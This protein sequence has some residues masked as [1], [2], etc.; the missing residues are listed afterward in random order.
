MW[1]YDD[2][3]N[4][5]METITHQQPELSDDDLAFAAW[6]EQAV[7]EH[8]ARANDVASSQEGSAL[9][10][11]PRALA[12]A[13]LSAVLAIAGCAAPQ[14]NCPAEPVTYQQQRATLDHEP[15]NTRPHHPR[16]KKAPAGDACP[17]NT[18]AQECEAAREYNRCMRS[19]DG[20]TD[21]QLSRTSAILTGDAAS[22]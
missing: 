19:P 20:C 3:T 8:G 11:A 1:E 13:M 7:A 22:Q 15:A 14:S 17:E 10:L 18:T 5:E 16:A 21:E 4:D 9:R 12:L 6:L 2:F